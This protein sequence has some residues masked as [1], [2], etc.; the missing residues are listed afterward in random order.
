MQISY[1]VIESEISTTGG[2]G[3]YSNCEVHTNYGNA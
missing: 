3:C 2:V 1:E